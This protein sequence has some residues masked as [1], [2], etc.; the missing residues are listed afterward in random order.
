MDLSLE[1]NGARLTLAFHTVLFLRC[2]FWG[3]FTAAT[4]TFLKQ[5]PTSAGDANLEFENA[6]TQYL[7]AS[8]TIES[9][10]K[11]L[12]LAEKIYETSR[13]KFKE[14]IGS[15]LEITSAERDVY[16]TQANLL[17]AQINLINAKVDLDKSMGKL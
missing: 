8:T 10:K 11:S 15:S 5:S 13:I 4:S 6:R 16:Q 1:T 12:A 14:G 3:D 9:R 2:R 7:N 17:D